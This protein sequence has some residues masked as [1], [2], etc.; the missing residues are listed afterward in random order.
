MEKEEYNKPKLKSD[1]VEIGTYG[2]YQ[3]TPFCATG[4]ITICDPPCS[5]ADEP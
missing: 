5:E 3:P 1:T 4:S 2:S